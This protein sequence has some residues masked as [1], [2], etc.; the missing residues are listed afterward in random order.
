M[1]T[2]PPRKKGFA[3]ST[4][5]DTGFSKRGGGDS[6]KVG[7]NCSEQQRVETSCLGYTEVVVNCPAGGALK[8]PVIYVYFTSNNDTA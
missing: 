7:V 1:I 6:K 8:H 5:T 4:V 3:P 2:P